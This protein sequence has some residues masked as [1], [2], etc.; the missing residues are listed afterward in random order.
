M[1]RPNLVQAV[2]IAHLLRLLHFRVLGG[3]PPTLLLVLQPPKY[4]AWYWELLLE[5]SLP[6]FVLCGAEIPY[7]I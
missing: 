3:V 7:F 1:R 6:F 2:I 5:V 4:I